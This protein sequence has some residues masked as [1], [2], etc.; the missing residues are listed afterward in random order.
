MYCKDKKSYQQFG[1]N[2]FFLVFIYEER[3][4]LRGKK[5]IY[6]KG[7]KEMRKIDLSKIAKIVQLLKQKGLDTTMDIDEGTLHIRKYGRNY[8]MERVELMEHL[9][10]V[11]LPE[12]SIVEEIS[13]C[14]A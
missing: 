5:Y 13:R 9:C 3:V 7:K 11:D 2:V 14:F 6:F 1:K 8:T 10:F 4:I 12:E